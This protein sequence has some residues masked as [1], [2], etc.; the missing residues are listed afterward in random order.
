[1]QESISC[2]DYVADRYSLLIMLRTLFCAD[3][4][5]D[6]FAGGLCDSEKQQDYDY[7]LQGVVSHVGSSIFAGHYVSDVYDQEAYRWHN[8]NDSYVEEV[9]LRISFCKPC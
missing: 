2:A 7:D 1:M 5:A 4:V 3:Y 9:R 8:Y 6:P